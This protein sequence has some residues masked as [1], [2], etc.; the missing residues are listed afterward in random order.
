MSSALV[1]GAP[2]AGVSTFLGLLY[3]A[4]VRLGSDVD[5]AYRFHIDRASLRR[6]EGIYGELGD[7]R[8]PESEVDWSRTPISFLVAD[9][10]FGRRR[11]VS[12]ADDD[13]DASPYWVEIGGL[14]T[15]EAVEL[16]QRDAI[17]DA[18]LRRLLRSRIVLPIVDA[19]WLGESA[20]GPGAR[21]GREDVR[22]AAALELLARFV[23]AERNRRARR[24][25]PL[26]VLTK[27]DRLAP[28]AR[29]RLGIP[30]GP[31]S[32]WAPEA[33]RE[34]GARFLAA[35]LPE[36]DRALGRARERGIEVAPPMWFF[37]EVGTEGDL[38]QRIR[39]RWRPPSGGWE[40][41]YPF[42]E[43][44]ALLDRLG[45]LVHRWPDRGA[46]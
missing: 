22:L 35:D 32:G 14:T 12:A 10:R 45:E 6:L 31:P 38:G 3:T 5:D 23:A 1:V 41:D 17:L 20:G 19:S 39:R 40:P 29:H 25:F 11:G 16:G 26:F 46:T 44:R 13:P 30:D 27:F 42:E 33:R 8:F 36:T 28:R 24:L 9:R 2:G 34:L 15:D 37:S 21:A 18:P 43:Y 7:G 4:E